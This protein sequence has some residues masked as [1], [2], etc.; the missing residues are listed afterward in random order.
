MV[1]TE[2][3]GMNLKLPSNF[4]SPQNEDDGIAVLHHLITLSNGWVLEGKESTNVIL[5]STY[6]QRDYINMG[7]E[8]GR[9]NG[10]A[11]RAASM[12]T[13]NQIFLQPVS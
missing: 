4:S 11:T 3:Y 12:S 7:F 13:H 5:A 6:K 9:A 1:F 10:V 2:T 8:Y